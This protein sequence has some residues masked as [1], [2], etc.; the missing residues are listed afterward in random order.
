MQQ[1]T[2]YKSKLKHNE[3]S[4]YVLP[5]YPQADHLD[6]T[7]TALPRS[8]CYCKGIEAEERGTIEAEAKPWGTSLVASAPPKH[9]LMEQTGDLLLVAAA[10]AAMVRKLLRET[11]LFS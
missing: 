9:R 6:Q 10:A 7:K 8:R 11:N 5:S 1:K 4:T 2:I 3:P